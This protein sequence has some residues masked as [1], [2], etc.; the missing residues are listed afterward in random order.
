MVEFLL[1]LSFVILSLFTYG[2]MRKDFPKVYVI[3]HTITIS[4]IV[5]LLINLSFYYGVSNILVGYLLLAIVVSLLVEMEYLSRHPLEVDGL[6]E[7]FFAT[8]FN[9]VIIGITF[10]AFY[11]LVIR[12]IPESPVLVQLFEFFGFVLVYFIIQV[13][14]ARM[15][16]RIRVIQRMFLPLIA[17]IAISMSLVSYY[18]SNP[19]IGIEPTNPRATI[20]GRNLY[21]DNLE[22]HE[23]ESVLDIV[24]VDNYIY[25]VEKGTEQKLYAYD[26]RNGTDTLLFTSVHSDNYLMDYI[27]LNEYAGVIYVTTQS[28][29][30]FLENGE[31]LEMYL[32]NLLVGDVE[33]EDF[34]G[35]LYLNSYSETNNTET[36]FYETE[37]T[38]YM[39]SGD[40]LVEY[41]ENYDLDWLIG[42]VNPGYDKLYKFAR[43]LELYIVAEYGDTFIVNGSPLITHATPIDYFNS[44]FRFFNTVLETNLPDY[45]YI[46]L[47]NR[48]YE[49]A[50][51]E[52]NLCT[53]EFRSVFD[54]C[55]SSTRNN[56]ALVL[57]E[58]VVYLVTWNLWVEDFASGTFAYDFDVYTL[59]PGYLSFSAYPTNAMKPT[60]PWIFVV[61]FIPLYQKKQSL[62]DF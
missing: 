37:S 27:C 9:A 52:N 44:R 5:T 51:R 46:R 17:I 4:L 59:A 3:I 1:L 39:V 26:I 40:S 23:K 45:L 12:Y 49:L 61:F 21:I 57:G 62:Y 2:Y 19:E 47:A 50:T 42:E 60:C 24:M 25:Y 54:L 53:Y 48:V 8:L 28:G 31:L 13:L 22:N 7:K 6:R 32:H 36:L 34:Y 43:K 20:L 15:I 16:S 30:Y 29:L 33:F 38:L 58:N 11:L 41:P 55:I 18:Y 35:V 56:E 10:N 14:Y